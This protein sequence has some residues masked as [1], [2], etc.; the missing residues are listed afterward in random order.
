MGLVT[1]TFRLKLFHPAEPLRYYVQRFTSL[2][3]MYL[4][5]PWIDPNTE[6]LICSAGPV[7]YLT[8][9]EIDNTSIGFKCYAYATNIHGR[10]SIK[11]RGERDP[12]RNPAYESK[13]ATFKNTFDKE[14]ASFIIDHNAAVSD[15][16]SGYFDPCYYDDNY[17]IN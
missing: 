11:Y 12:R 4:T 17:F 9:L 13:M 15:S 6:D 16:M 3:T 1:R 7:P 14:I 8:D 2:E 10:L 5:Y